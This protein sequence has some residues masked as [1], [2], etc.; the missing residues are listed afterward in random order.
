MF[1]PTRI[2]KN[3]TLAVVPNPLKVP[4]VE[5]VHLRRL[6]R[7]RSC[8]LAP[9]DITVMISYC[10]QHFTVVAPSIVSDPLPSMVTA[11]KLESVFLTR[12]FLPVLPTAVG[13]VI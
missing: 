11:L 7:F 6:A 1:S 5:L 2:Q 3:S 9:S 12:N 4:G 8:Q 13:S 10:V